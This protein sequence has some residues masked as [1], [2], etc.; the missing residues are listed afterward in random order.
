MP[1]DTP[2]K[3]H[4][5]Q[6]RKRP[7]VGSVPNA[8]ADPPL[9][10]FGVVLSAEGKPLDELR[11]EAFDADL[12]GTDTLGS[13]T[14]D[15]RGR[16]EIGY[17]QASFH[18]T[19]AERG[20][21]ELFVRVEDPF[22]RL[23]Y[24]SPRVANAPP[25][26]RIDAVIAMPEESHPKG[27]YLVKGRV[28]STDLPSLGGLSAAVLE[29]GVGAAQ[30]L[31]L[32][33]V[34]ADGSY[35][36]PL[37]LGSRTA[38]GLPDLLVA[39][40][41]GK[42]T[43]AQ[44]A[45]VIDA[46]PGTVLI[47]VALPPGLT[48]SQSEFETV[49]LKLVG[50]YGDQ[51]NQVDDA[52]FAE[53]LGYVA[54][55]VG[56]DA[57]ALAMAR[58]A[59]RYGQA[60][61]DKPSL[62]AELYY[63][64][65]RAGVPGTHGAPF[66]V[67][68]QTA[69]AIWTQ[70]SAAGVI[71]KQSKKRL[72]AAEKTF[73]ELAT[74]ISLDIQPVPGAST[75]G[76]QLAVSFGDDQAAKRTLAGLVA[77]HADDTVKFWKEV[78]RVFGVTE[79]DRLQVDAALL[80][81]SLGSATMVRNLRQLLPDA[82]GNLD[83]LALRGFARSETWLP[84][85]AD[86][87][88]P[89]AIDGADLSQ[90]RQRY[91]EL[92]AAQVRLAH[93]VAA[94]AHDVEQGRV[95]V[96]RRTQDAVASFYTAHRNSYRLGEEPLEHYLAKTDVKVTDDVR[97]ELKKIERIYQLTPTDDAM[98]VLLSAG[99]HSAYQ[100][101]QF[102]PTQ[103]V[104]LF[105]KQLGGESVARVVIAK[106]QEVHTAVVNL[107]ITYHAAQSSPPI[108]PAN[109]PIMGQ[110]TTQQALSQANAPAAATLETLF[111]EL[112]YCAC[113]HCRSILSP[114][115]YFVSLLQLC[116]PDEA[117][118]SGRRPIDEL[119]LRRPDLEHLPL[120]C[121][122]TNTPLPHIDL[123]NETLE[124]FVDSVGKSA[125][126]LAGYTGFNTDPAVPPQ[127][128]L[129]EP[130]NVRASAYTALAT[131]KF[132]LVLPFSEPLESLRQYLKPFGTT[133]ARALE[134]VRVDDSL[135]AVNPAPFAWRDILIEEME[136]S[137]GEYVLLTDRTLTIRELYGFPAG[138]A[139]DPAVPSS[140]RQARS[141]ARRVGISFEELADLLETRFVNP[142]A[143][144]IPLASQLGVSLAQIKAFDDTTNDPINNTAFEAQ[145]S[146]GLDK[147]QFGGSV[148]T[149]VRTH[150]K[151]ILGLLTLFNTAVEPDPCDFS[152]MEFRYGDP[153]AN[154][155]EV[156][157]IEFVRLLR[158]IRIW[159]KLKWPAASRDE[160]P[161]PWSIAE[162]D[163]A[164][165]A[166]Y[167]ISQLPLDSSEATNLER[168][169]AGCKTLLLRL[170]AL[171]RLMHGLDVR[172]AT[173]LDSL[174]ACVAPMQNA[175][176]GTLYRSLFLSAGFLRE[177]PA[178]APDAGAQPVADNTALIVD[179]VRALQAVC[180]LSARDYD[181]IVQ[182]LGPQGAPLPATATL[183][184][185]PTA[186]EL[187]QLIGGR[188]PVPA[189]TEYLLRYLRTETI[190][191]V[192]RRAWIARKL[193]LSV[194]ELLIISR[195]SGLNFE[196]ELGSV[197]SAA[198]PNGFEAL[199]RLVGTVR[200][201]GLTPAEA[202]LVIWNHDLLSAGPSAR[203]AALAFAVSA[204]AELAAV[205]RALVPADDPDS[206]LLT[207]LLSSVLGADTAS[208][209][210][211]FAERRA[212]SE[213]AYAHT[214]ATL[215][216][217]VLQA[218]D[219]LAY[220]DLL[221]RLSYTKGVMPPAILTA[222]RNPALNQPQAFLDAITT[223][224]A[225][226]QVFFQ[227]LNQPAL[228]QAHDAYLVSTAGAEVKRR[229]LLS[230]VIDALKP[231]RRR[232]AVVERA[233]AT[234]DAGPEWLVPLLS[235]PALLCSAQGVALDA[236]QDFLAVDSEGVVGE[237]FF[238]NAVG[239]VA[240]ARDAGTGPIDYGPTG[241][242]T[243]PA[244]TL[245]SGQPIAGR[246]SGYV[247]VPAPGTVN[248]EIELDAA[249][250]SPTLTLGGITVALQSAGGGTA[251]W[252]NTDV[253]R[254]PP[255]TLVRFE[256]VVMGV[257]TKV[258]LAWQTAS[259]ARSMVPGVALYDLAL[260][261]NLVETYVRVLRAGLLR[262]KLALSDPEALA[263]FAQPSL[264]IG[265]DTAKRPLLG[266]LP[267]RGAPTAS[268]AVELGKKLAAIAG[269]IRVRRELPA[270]PE[271]MLSLLVD[272]MAAVND[273]NGP[274]VKLSGWSAAAVDATLTRLKVLNATNQPD[275]LALR[276]PAVALRV[277]DML[278][279]VKTLGISHTTVLASISNAPLGSAVSN[280]YAA[281][282]AQSSASAWSALIKPINDTLRMRRRDA[283]VAFALVGLSN[284]PSRASIDTPDRLYEYLLL[285]VLIH[286][287]VETSRIRQAIAAV[288]QFIQR[289]VDLPNSEPKDIEVPLAMR[290][291]WP[292]MKRY[293]VWEANRKV[294]LYPEN[295][296]E[297]ELRDDQSPIFRETMSELLQGDITEERAAEA[298]VGYVRKLE[299][300][301][302]LEPC[303]IHVDTRETAG[304]A[305]DDVMHVVARS[306]GANRKYHYRR[307]EPSGWTPWE[308]VKLDVEDNPV[309]PVR[310]K[311]R[312]YLFWLK[313]IQEAGEA[314]TPSWSSGRLDR[315]VVGKPADPT[316]RVKAMLCWS[317]YA[318]GKWGPTRTSSI[319]RA[320]T[321]GT[322]FTAPAGSNPFRR[323]QYRL[324][325]EL[326]LDA[327]DV[328]ID[329]LPGAGLN[330]V[331]R[332][333]GYRLYNSFADPDVLP[334]TTRPGSHTVIE[335]IRPERNVWVED[336][337][338]R[339]ALRVAYLPNGGTRFSAP[340]EHALFRRID[341]FG[342]SAVAPAYDVTA[343]WTRTAPFFYKD[344]K[345]A[346]Y[347]TPVSV[348][349]VGLVSWRPLQSGKG[350]FQIADRSIKA[351]DESRFQAEAARFSLNIR[352]RFAVG[353]YETDETGSI[354]KI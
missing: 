62:P 183:A 71:S 151:S 192:Y 315:A 223:L 100:V 267:T 268:A 309:L 94:L 48:T 254:Y 300:I 78:G 199:I 221:K 319:E 198:P 264:A 59:L 93:P 285:D 313:V 184:T 128:L 139:G 154:G 226:S 296:L 58:L 44:S 244:N 320:V 172:D 240:D 342:G 233:V 305:A 328:W 255:G 193:R 3:T 286:P 51:L 247:E 263:L 201:A 346:F 162:V 334:P 248:L 354:V 120:T 144:V 110:Q 126:T 270:T 141:F 204:R 132:P 67:S 322:T 105:A 279:L 24:E 188:A 284:D 167:P 237:Y 282:R 1:K 111:G 186:A 269:Y 117:P 25:N 83:A 21:P 32:V 166:L 340:N 258:K 40:R 272:P 119:R 81:L 50:V 76:E 12:S 15:G 303:G 123:V 276:N 161:R 129:T 135:D 134:A 301:S 234:L 261:D 143:W 283:L 61:G 171:L 253:L 63:A 197:N 278:H 241:T 205:E 26:Q 163:A 336:P 288:Q 149:W 35:E 170:G 2:K 36:A 13:T 235:T 351:V 176:P 160:A 6:T 146:A 158:F 64:L 130:Q 249:A 257:Q 56:W 107:A 138:N 330:V 97:T 180:Q 349:T 137:R 131:A 28:R 353:A 14:T 236:L 298:M 18:K 34:A 33:P 266:E 224:A 275:R 343:T 202:L 187:Q 327:L 203:E 31:A 348:T 86:A 82:T 47:D 92:L 10:V 99:I 345:Y 11:V 175:G 75:L 337:R 90:R 169:D 206:A 159:R 350:A 352:S 80:D 222:L 106:A 290:E 39:V 232:Q 329:P 173:E 136:L 231:A 265:P 299:E 217:A 41:D 339:S 72:A 227:E 314:T 68:P 95:P 318:R 332:E 246:W 321:L 239:A 168:L 214:N 74:E 295:W 209:Y 177:Y 291:Q 185:Q 210:L 294:F 211:D 274:F 316:H 150:A 308:P 195:Y 87:E 335:R 181:L 280:M 260:V 238:T 191:R 344:A 148:T 331:F 242:R 164:L 53:K 194:E 69:V 49:R 341:G 52:A 271:A 127:D 57:R 113:E 102:A 207:Q 54:A 98:H 304:D 215:S 220:D 104:Q 112:D 338:I 155:S 118:Q 306:S 307:R 216:D 326:R 317:E 225:Q 17:T 228:R 20:G 84:L 245:N 190:S 77:A 38:G 293:R 196:D 5:R 46:M 108:G 281:L 27:R 29:F 325:A 250:P 208:S 157:A 45:V 37:D 19:S 251:V 124:Y 23:L 273:T 91:A 259:I 4:V 101:A 89:A 182:E 8:P 140:L 292:W 16:Y 60:A 114:A 252:R 230:A 179:N 256:L 55:K 116:D 152:Q 297:P 125:L 121:E 109:A 277:H 312:L 156:R 243:L 333:H 200:A 178:F 153:T 88:I 323:E 73:L 189:E 289:L 85:V 70:A 42:K 262:Q 145:L 30:E 66:R 103:F 310:W 212:R 324:R 219:G 229:N 142:N 311:G 147:A 7:R 79:R 287:R 213:V 133:L 218:G 115:A 65:F 122:N 165:T 22:G 174:L 302:M 43:L 347:I 9:L 96:E